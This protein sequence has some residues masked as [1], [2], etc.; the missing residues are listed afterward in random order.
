[1][2]KNNLHDLPHNSSKN[3]VCKVNNLNLSAVDSVSCAQ[4]KSFHPDYAY[5][6]QTAKLWH[7]DEI[8]SLDKNIQLNKH[9]DYTVQYGDCLESI[10]LRALKTQ[11]GDKQVNA[12]Q[13]DNEVRKIVELNHKSYPSLKCNDSLILPGW[14]LKIPDFTCKVDRPTKPVPV[15]SSPVKDVPDCPK[16]VIP[17]SQPTEPT[18]VKYNYGLPT[19]K[20]PVTQPDQPTDSGSCHPVVVKPDCGCHAVPVNP[21]LEPAPPVSPPVENPGV[22]VAPAQPPYLGPTPV[23]P[24]API[25]PPVNMPY[26]MPNSGYLNMP[27]VTEAR[28]PEPGYLPRPYEI[29]PYFTGPT[30]PYPNWQINQTY[31]QLNPYQSDL[32]PQERY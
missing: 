30:I 15:V 3:E 23:E 16:P 21:P 13:I 17:V 10:A 26:P 28:P 12:A 27:P 6:S 8:E 2:D 1:M 20:I 19:W 18:E 4:A 25:M 14:Q 9:C 24:P 32:P 29:P 22:P 7:K 5:R 31:S 11:N